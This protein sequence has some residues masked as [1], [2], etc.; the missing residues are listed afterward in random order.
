MAA[1][2]LVLAAGVPIAAIVLTY[3]VL[4]EDGAKSTGRWGFRRQT[5]NIG[6]SPYRAAESTEELPQGAPLSLRFMC[7]LSAMSGVATC[8]LLA[9]AGMLLI[10]A[11]G[12]D[13]HRVACLMVFLVS[14]SGFP[15]GVCLVRVARQV[16]RN[17]AV[18][19]SAFHYL[20]GH[21]VCVALTMIFVDI[22]SRRIEV[23]AFSVLVCLAVVV[24]LLVLHGSAKVLRTGERAE[25]G[26]RAPGC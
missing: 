25:A 24:P 16:T 21:H 5:L 2:F 14:L 15:A 12:E 3:L 26:L 7:W 11:V 23:A 1:I 17:E 6:A 9:P 19:A 4:F 22:A 13:S 10:L 8:A 20:Y 18:P